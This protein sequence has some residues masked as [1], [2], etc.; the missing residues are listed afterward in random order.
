MRRIPDREI[1]LRE[2]CAACTYGV[3]NVRVTRTFP[4]LFA[5]HAVAI[6]LLTLYGARVCPLI[7]SLG[8]WQLA[9]ILLACFSVGIAVKIAAVFRFRPH[10]V[11]AGVGPWRFVPLDVAI[12]VGVAVLFSVCNWLFWGFPFWTSGM[13]MAVGTATLGFFASVSDALARE[14]FLLDLAERGEMS[15]FSSGNPLRMATRFR[16]FVFTSIVLMASILSLLLYKDLVMEPAQQAA[17]LAQSRDAVEAADAKAAMMAKAAA[18][19]AAD[20]IVVPRRLFNGIFGEVLFVIGV[21]LGCTAIVT[22]QYGTNLRRMF[23]LELRA[24]RQV[25][26]GNLAVNVPVISRDELAEIADG[27]NGMIAGLRE[28]EQIRNTFG[29]YVS[30]AIAKAILGDGGA[31]LGGEQRE[32][33]I[34]FTDLRDYTTLSEK[35]SPEQMVALLNEYFS[36]V[37]QVIDRHGGFVN[38]FIG[39]AAMA[40]FGLDGSP[41]SCDAAVRAALEIRERLV[42]L[43]QTFLAKG[44][45]EIANGIGIHHGVLIAGNIG[46]AERLEYT[47]IGD[48]VNTASRLESLT[49]SLGSFVAVSSVVHARLSP[50]VARALAPRGEHQLKGKAAATTV[51]GAAA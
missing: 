16:I 5:S 37:V 3:D 17:R 39:D 32:A 35:V 12:W 15:R 23:D 46:S 27:T 26:E 14:H 44:W 13:K 51:Y 42:V 30:P 1:F 40:V 49:K 25:R 21:I 19:E 41:A 36:M 8:F 18:P 7:E 2:M 29:K 28:K 38:K 34:L 4:R 47:V 20:T 24:L 48:T 10:D 33:T 31:R 11:A 9:G 45:P 22:Q 50:D 43:N 6:L